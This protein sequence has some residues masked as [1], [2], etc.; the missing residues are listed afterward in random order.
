MKT[1]SLAFYQPQYEEQLKAFYLPPHQSDF[2]VL[3]YEAL[4]VSQEDEER[5]PVVILQDGQVAG[6]FVLH[7]WG[8]VQSYSTN[9][10]A[11]LL[12][13]FSVHPNFQG[14][15]IASEAIQ[16]LPKFVREHFPWCDE[17]VLGVNH[18]NEAAQRVYARNGFVDQGNRVMGRKGEQ[19]VM[20]MVLK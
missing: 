13:A 10:S 12:R 4:Q 19:Y 5:H 17:I 7:G 3:P 6:F 2:T 20:H 15:G 9:T 14:Q 18:A 1:I 16:I 11:M 8:G